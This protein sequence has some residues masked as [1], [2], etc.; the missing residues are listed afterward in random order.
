MK[1]GVIGSGHMGSSLIQGLIHS[2]LKPEE[3]IASDPDEEKLEELK[4]LGI[5]VTKDNVEAMKKSS[6]TFL[7]VKPDLVTE[8]LREL[9]ASEDELIVSI[10]AGVPIDLLEENT[11]ARV[12]RVM[13]NICGKVGE[14]ASCY[15]RGDSATE[16]D[17]GLINGILSDLGLTFEVEEKLMDSI[18]GLSGSGPAFAFL[19]IQGLKEA[20]IDLGL[21]KEMAEKMAAQTVKGSG[22]I[23]LD[24]NQSVEELI[25]A[26]CTPKGTTI[27]G[28]RVL[29]D[30]GVKEA[31]KKA[32]KAAVDRAKELSK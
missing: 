32:V 27:E 29:E 9:D 4:E 16:E 24:S 21:P 26:V 6:L 31:F 28:V 19:M 25:D 3:I 10:A 7:A 23:V 18:T 12:I 5:N 15:T 8:V 30:Q 14:M 20:G 17:L 22:E 2:G 13:P 11:N 1:V